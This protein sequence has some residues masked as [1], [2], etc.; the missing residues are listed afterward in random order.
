MTIG[1]HT[2]SSVL[3]ITA[4]L[5]LFVFH[6]TSYAVSWSGMWSQEKKAYKKATGESKPGGKSDIINDLKKVDKLFKNFVK[7]PSGKT[8]TSLLKAVDKF[9]KDKE[10]YQDILKDSLKENKDNKKKVTALIDLNNRL[11]EISADIKKQIEESPFIVNEKLEAVLKMKDLKDCKKIVSHRME[12][13]IIKDFMENSAYIGEITNFL[14]EYH[15]G[16]ING[17][18]AT[19]LYN[20]N[21]DAKSKQALNLSTKNDRDPVKE[22][23]VDKYDKDQCEKALANVEKRVCANLG[24]KM[25]SKVEFDNP[26]RKWFKGKK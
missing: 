24:E 16:G 17:K 18:K 2:K 5:F 13:D 9:E 15:K 14:D 25:S 4:L 8:Q 26:L 1:N 3:V 12:W 20:E 23:C 10:K 22:M 6:S 7:K 19:E 21:I 11:D